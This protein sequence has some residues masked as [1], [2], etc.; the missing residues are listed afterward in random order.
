MFQTDHPDDRFAPGPTRLFQPNPGDPQAD[1][2][3][4]LPRQQV[5]IL[6]VLLGQHASPTATHGCG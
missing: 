2:N 5:V 3:S 4:S 6:Q 1:G